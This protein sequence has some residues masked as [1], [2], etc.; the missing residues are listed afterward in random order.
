MMWMWRKINNREIFV[1][2]QTV[3]L[4]HASIDEETNKTLNHAIWGSWGQPFQNMSDS[5][6]WAGLNKITD[7]NKSLSSYVWVVITHSIGQLSFFKIFGLDR[8]KPSEIFR[9]KNHKKSA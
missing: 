3:G 5:A 6:Q 1:L 2:F 8:G 9:V 4:K 7:I